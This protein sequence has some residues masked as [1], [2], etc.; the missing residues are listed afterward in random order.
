MTFNE[1]KKA[2]Y[3]IHRVVREDEIQDMELNQTNNIKEVINSSDYDT[4]DT[5]I[6][7]AYTGFD[8]FDPAG[9]LIFSVDN[10]ELDDLEMALNNF[11]KDLK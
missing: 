1:F 10:E 7:S 5:Y 6:D 9:D 2:G 8:I 4:K 3:S 11:I